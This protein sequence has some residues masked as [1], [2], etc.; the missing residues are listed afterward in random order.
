MMLPPGDQEGELVDAVQG[1]VVEADHYHV[2]DDSPL[3]PVLP[4]EEVELLAVHQLE[5]LLGRENQRGHDQ[6]DPHD[7]GGPRDPGEQSEN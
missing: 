1:V 4:V 3:D 2:D 7:D 5:H 6:E